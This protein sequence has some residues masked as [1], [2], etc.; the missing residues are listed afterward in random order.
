M[1]PN[2]ILVRNMAGV[3]IAMAGIT[4]VALWLGRSDRQPN[5]ATAR[6]TPPVPRPL[7]EVGRRTF[8]AKGCVACHT[9]DGSPRVGPSF[10][11]S[12]GSIV[13][14]GEG[15]TL[16]FDEAYVRESIAWPHAKARPGYPPS[17]PSYEGLLAAKE[18]DGLIE[19]IRS[20]E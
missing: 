10:K 11:G 7:L 15:V 14:L 19:F 18:I 20:L 5:V 12:W 8:D 17:M 2:Q 13:V 4:T 16:V 9:T 6:A 3:V 1:S